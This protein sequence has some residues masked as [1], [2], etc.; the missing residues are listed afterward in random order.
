MQLYITK[1]TQ[2]YTTTRINSRAAVF[3][4]LQCAQEVGSRFSFIIIIIIIII[5]ARRSIIWTKHEHAITTTNFSQITMTSAPSRAAKTL[6][7]WRPCL[8]AHAGGVVRRHRA[9]LLNGRVCRR[10]TQ[11]WTGAAGPGTAAG[12][13]EPGQRHRR[14]EC[15]Q[16][17]HLRPQVRQ[18]H[19]LLHQK[20]YKTPN[21]SLPSVY[22]NCPVCS[23]ASTGW[24]RVDTVVAF[25]WSSVILLHWVHL[26]VLS[27]PIPNVFY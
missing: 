12:T 9:V 2:V 19:L 27:C 17:G 23:Y 6:A 26:N 5:I 20:S 13:R 8:L 16:L 1:P 15:H 21:Q 3:L 11:R 24:H 22:L 7:G 18:L 14:H 10:V 4:K 25:P